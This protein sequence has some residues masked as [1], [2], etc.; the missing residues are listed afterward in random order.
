M[1]LKGWKLIIKHEIDKLMKQHDIY[2]NSLKEKH[3][4]DLELKEK[5]HKL[6]IEEIRIENEQDIL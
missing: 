3:K 4:M 5:K 1:N 2:I 6:K